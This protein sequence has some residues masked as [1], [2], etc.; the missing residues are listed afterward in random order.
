MK[1]ALTHSTRKNV[2]AFTLVEVMLALAVVSIGIIAILGLLPNALQ[3]SRDAADNTL[4]AT[5]VQD[6]FSSIR[7]QPFHKADFGAGSKDLAVQVLPSSPVKL[8]YDSTGNPTNVLDYYQV[9]V[10]I[11]PQP[12]LGMSYVRAAVLWPA[13][14]GRPVTNFFVTGVAQYD[15]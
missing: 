11:E 8:N 14:S 15:Q 1:R 5:I 9:L 4:A 3:S 2:H 7:A 6:L 13:H 12:P 10:S